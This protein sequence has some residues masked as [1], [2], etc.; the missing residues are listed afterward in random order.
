MIPLKECTRTQCLGPSCPNYSAH[1]VEI[2]G[3]ALVHPEQIQTRAIA[4]I[5]QTL[6][7]SITTT[8]TPTD[9]QRYS[10]A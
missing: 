10:N 3:T 4:Q 6:D 5:Q 8:G 2:L 1:R 7:A 9:T